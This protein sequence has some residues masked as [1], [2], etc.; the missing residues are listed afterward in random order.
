MQPT[1]AA[2]SNT[3][4][5]DGG[6]RTAGGAVAC[7]LCA[8]VAGQDAPLLP[9]GV[10]PDVVQAVARGLDYL[11]RSQAHDGAWRDAGGY[12]TYP[13]AM[14]GLAGMALSAAGST[15][16]RG[17]HWREVR[18]AMEYLLRLAD[19]RTGMIADLGTENR[20]MYGH[21]FS[22]L[23]LASVYGMEEDVVQQEKLHGVLTRA[24]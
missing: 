3:C 23:F 24:V 8:A 21:G 17:R 4:R 19:P 5:R 6:R 7:A 9:R 14:T 15:P 13:A 2:Q 18:E 12:G 22:T 16:T 20:N 1:A 10:T 11:A